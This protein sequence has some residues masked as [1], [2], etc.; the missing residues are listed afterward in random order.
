M[1]REG[2]EVGLAWVSGSDNRVGITARGEDAT[3]PNPQVINGVAV[4][5]SYR[6]WRIGPLLDWAPAAKSRL[7]LRGGRLERSYTQLPAR[8]YAA[9]TWNLNYEWQATERLTLTALARNDLSEYEQVNVGLVAVRGFALQPAFRFGEK[10]RL[11]LSFGRDLRIYHGDAVLAPGVARVRERL[12][13]LDLRYS[14]QALRM[15]GL[16]LQLRQ[17]ARRSARTPQYDALI[18]GLAVRATF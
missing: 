1:R 4:D 7:Q 18:A 5:N 11:A 17:E 15:L 2:V 13:V 10:S 14:W 6:Q 12:R 8:D 16:D 3:L 9:W